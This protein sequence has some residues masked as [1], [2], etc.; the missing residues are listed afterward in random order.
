MFEGEKPPLCGAGELPDVKFWEVEKSGGI[1]RNVV[2]VR[3]H[4]D[5]REYGVRY[6]EGLETGCSWTMKKRGCP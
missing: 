4:F 3:G 1:S 5:G 6:A 2:G